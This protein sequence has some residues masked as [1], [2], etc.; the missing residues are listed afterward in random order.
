[1]WIDSHSHVSDV[2]SDGKKKPD[3]T[4]HFIDVL[5]RSEIDLRLLLSVDAVEMPATLKDAEALMEGNRFIHH[6]VTTAPGRLYG[7]CMV[8][9]HHLDFSLRTMEE[10]FEKFHFV[11]LGEMLQYMMGYKMNSDEVER[12]IKQA[13][14]YDVPVQVHISTSNAKMHPSTFGTEQLMDL[15]GLVE[16]VPEAKY[17]L[18][19]LVGH[20]K[21]DP[22]IVDEYLD[23]IDK[24]SSAWPENFWVEIRDFNS[25]GVK[26]VL[27]RV[28][29]DRI[30]AG[31]DYSPRGDP[32]F[33]DY[34]ILDVGVL[35]DENP[36]QLTINEMVDCMKQFGITDD[37][38]RKIACKNA[39]SLFKIRS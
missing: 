17:I 37:T 1:M 3:F 19:H 2:T 22:P 18:A 14:Q 33:N 16:R 36:S 23:I 35:K 28:P 34:G 6:T 9:P 30:L 21:N 29:H 11:M 5:N 38:V 27:D 32:P 20:K 10:C 7:S 13:L 25:P 12:L 4:K 24:Y 15:L 39:L 26:S 31:T 8:N